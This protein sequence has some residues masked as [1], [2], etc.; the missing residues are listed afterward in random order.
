MLVKMMAGL[1]ATLAV[2][3][4]SADSEAWK[5]DESARSVP[6][7]VPYASPALPVFDSVAKNPEASPRLASFDSVVFSE[8]SA[9]L[10]VFNSLPTVGFW[11]IVK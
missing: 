5:Y 9:V 7:P 8:D 10:S 11:L 6:L 1:I 4:A 3:T 2:S